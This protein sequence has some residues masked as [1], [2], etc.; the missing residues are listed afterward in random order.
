MVIM[1]LY[2]VKLYV[3]DVANE[4]TMSRVKSQQRDINGGS[5][6]AV[7]TPSPGSSGTPSPTSPTSPTSPP[8]PAVPISY[9]EAVA[10]FFNLKNEYE[11]N[12][13]NVKR[14]IRKNP[15]GG[16]EEHRRRFA[17]HT[18]RCINC[19]GAGGTVF[20]VSATHF[21]AMCSAA[22]VPCNLNIEIKRKNVAIIEE[23]LAGRN[24]KDLTNTKNSVVSI[25]NQL[26]FTKS[27]SKTNT[28][29]LMNEVVE[30]IQIVEFVAGERE[31]LQELHVATLPDRKEIGKLTAEYSTVKH[32]QYLALAE[33][34]ETGRD[35]KLVEAVDL[36]RDR[37][38]PITNQIRGMRAKLQTVERGAVKDT[39]YFRQYE[40]LIKDTEINSELDDHDKA[41]DHEV[42]NFTM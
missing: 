15:T 31:D 17:A 8:P 16:T 14:R 10:K 42:V 23:V 7:S 18:F 9:N 37:I 12:R 25:K 34:T 2:Q 28:E 29:S 30:G 24:R 5:V 20:S 26:L 33:Y 19:G 36:Y 1:K 21:T 39:M 41:I 27:N 35:E 40:T 4:R 38:L 6:V 11:T 3:H 13:T 32:S 22:P